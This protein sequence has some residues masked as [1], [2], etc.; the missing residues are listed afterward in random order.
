M[1]AWFVMVAMGLFQTDG[2]CRVDPIY[3]LG[4]PLYPKVVLHLSKDYYGGKTFTI[5]ARNASKT[6]RY[7]QSAKLNG[8]PLD[9]WWIPQSKIIRGGTL[10]LELGP[11]PN[12]EWAAT[13]PLP[14][15]STGAP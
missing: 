12:E 10:E 9:S 3:E 11:Q 1:S 4:S 7:I 14:P 8:K 5:M 6:N 13:C 2:G 15:G